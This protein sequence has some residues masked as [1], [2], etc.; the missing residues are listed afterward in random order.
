[1]TLVE[2]AYALDHDGREAF[3]YTK[4]ELLVGPEQSGCSSWTWTAS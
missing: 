2:R 3:I 4:D 1:M